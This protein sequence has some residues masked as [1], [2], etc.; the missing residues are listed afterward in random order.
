MQEE[1]AEKIDA[2]LRRRWQAGDAIDSCRLP[3]PN[4]RFWQFRRAAHT[5]MNASAAITRLKRR[6]A[7]EEAQTSGVGQAVVHLAAAP[8]DSAVLSLVDN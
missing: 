1:A 5:V 7:W 2:G 3:S 4:R 8:T 6:R